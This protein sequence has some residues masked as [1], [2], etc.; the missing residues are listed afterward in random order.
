M[1]LLVHVIVVIVLRVVDVTVGLTWGP[2]G[3]QGFLFSFYGLVSA[4]PAIGVQVRRLHDIGKSGWFVL[5]AF[6]PI[7][8][9]FMLL[10]WY[11]QDS[12]PGDN[13]YGPTPKAAGA[14]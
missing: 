1:F 3:S 9:G 5:V 13:E 14:G 12:A 8:G 10:Y 11:V 6:I 7:V 2:H 4:L